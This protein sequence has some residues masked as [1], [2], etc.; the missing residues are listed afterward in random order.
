MSSDCK[1]SSN[2]PPPKKDK[3]K[4]E[5]TRHEP[6][7]E[8]KPCK[9]TKP[10]SKKSSEPTQ[11]SQHSPDSLG[12]TERQT[13]QNFHEDCIDKINTQINDEI[14]SAYTYI[15]MAS[16]CT[17]DN[18]ALFGFAKFFTHSY[19]EEIEHMEHLIAYLNKRGGQLRLTSIEAPSKQEWNT[20]EDLL[21]EALHMEKQLN[22]K[23]LK[24]HACASQHGDA[25]LTDFL[26][27][28]YLQEQVDAIKTLADLLTTVRR[29]QLY[30]VDRDLMS[31]KFSMHGNDNGE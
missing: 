15:S 12:K 19:K 14:R 29:T 11:S 30:L 26:E 18:V 21:T 7:K 23:L 17:Q 2:D 28:R 27:G 4:C 20:V 13:L 10:K 1:G 6:T 8:N 31:G 24:L 16:F 25:N 22:E 3:P 9:E 5:S